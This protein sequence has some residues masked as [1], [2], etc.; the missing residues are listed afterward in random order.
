MQP[1]LVQQPLVSLAGLLLFLGGLLFFRRQ[2]GLL[3]GLFITLLFFT[4]TGAPNQ[5][6]E[7]LRVVY[8]R[9]FRLGP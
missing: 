7:N 4:H 3:L 8:G 1:T 2:G 6:G 5:W 9:P